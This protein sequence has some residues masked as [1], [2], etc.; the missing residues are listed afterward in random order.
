M[1]NTGEQ[2][3]I[4]KKVAGKGLSHDKFF[5][6]GDYQNL[7]ARGTKLED[8]G[9]S[10]VQNA[11]F[12]SQ[13]EAEEGTINTKYMTPLRSK[14]AINAVVVIASE[15]EAAAGTN[16]TKYITPLRAKQAINAA[17]V[18]ASEEEAIVGSNN[19]KY[20]SPLRT[21]KAVEQYV[22]EIDPQL[23]LVHVAAKAWVPYGVDDTFTITAVDVSPAGEAI[24]IE[25][26]DPEDISQALSVSLVEGVII[27]SHATDE[28]GDI[29]TLAG[30]LETAINQHAEV[31]LIIQSAMGEAGTVDF[32]GAVITENYQIGVIAK[33]GKLL[34]D[35]TNLYLV[36]N[37]VDGTT[38]ATTDF[39]KIALAAV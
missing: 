5:A 7:R 24:E 16:N 31:G 37:D 26:V 20:M 9:L 3:R 29:S 19:T 30:N 34:S 22:V 12:A 33:A 32:V 35:T 27:V 14:Q 11:G 25:F 4:I 21:K 23:K 1:S 13:A 15:E 39:K 28:N 18:I 2:E 36:L 38:N 10:E 6:D 17:V 8:L